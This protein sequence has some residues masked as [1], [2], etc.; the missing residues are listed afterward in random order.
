MEEGEGGVIWND[1]QHGRSLCPLSRPH[2]AFNI[3][4]HI[5]FVLEVFF[6]MVS[7]EIVKHT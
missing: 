1:D 7:T 2:T 5:S 4:Q 3:L 6:T